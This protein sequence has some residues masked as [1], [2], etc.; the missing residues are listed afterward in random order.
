MEHP[1]L[2]G[3]FVLVVDDED[4][5]RELTAAIISAA[6]AHAESADSGERALQMLSVKRYDVLV[7]DIAMP[8]MDG[9]TLLKTLRQQAA[10]SSTVAALAFTAFSSPAD[11]A[12]L[13]AAGFDEHLGKASDASSLVSAVERLGTSRVARAS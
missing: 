1:M 8:T 9:M 2:S 6:G 5:A 11:R 12:T 7:C 3:L 4:D 13:L 10:P